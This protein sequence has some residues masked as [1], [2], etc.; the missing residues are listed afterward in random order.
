MFSIAT[1]TIGFTI[2]ALLLA[3]IILCVRYL[4]IPT[5][6]VPVTVNSDRTLQTQYAQT[7]LEALSNNNIHLPSACAGAGTCGLC[8]VQLEDK[9]RRQTQSNK[10][11]YHM[12]I[13][14]Q[15]FDWPAR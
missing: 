14:T 6:A 7:L 1:S 13:L 12:G 15:A 8:R 11:C 4:L 2:F 9:I 10:H 5:V 3:V